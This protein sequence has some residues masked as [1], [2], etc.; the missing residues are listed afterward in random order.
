LLS[1]IYFADKI[2]KILHFNNVLNQDLKYFKLSL[3]MKLKVNDFMD[4]SKYNLV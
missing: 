1:I 3:V 2:R 4:T